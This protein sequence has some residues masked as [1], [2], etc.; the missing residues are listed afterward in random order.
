MVDRTGRNSNTSLASKSRAR[1]TRLSDD[2]KDIRI[3]LADDDTQVRTLI[4]RIL[5]RQ[6]WQVSSVTNGQEAVEAWPADT[7]PFDLVILDINMPKLNGYQVYR[8]LRHTHPKAR[9]LFV[10]GYSD[11]NIWDKLV[12]E[13]LPFMVKPF[14]PNK[15]VEVVRELL[16]SSPPFEAT[17]TAGAIW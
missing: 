4:A 7:H 1:L 14:S 13:E 9:F 8:S 16:H 17:A 12:E 2:G 6:G 10:S 3:L 5:S 15:L 11:Q